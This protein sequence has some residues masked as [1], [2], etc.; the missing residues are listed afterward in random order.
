MRPIKFRA[1]HK[2]AREMLYDDDPGDCLVYRKQGQPVEVMQFTGL[3]DKNG[4]EIYEGDLIRYSD[5]IQKVEWV[6]GEWGYRGVMWA[7]KGEVIG[8]VHENQELLK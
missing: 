8:N 4:N 6:S 3:L 7:N 1:W 2:E 5:G